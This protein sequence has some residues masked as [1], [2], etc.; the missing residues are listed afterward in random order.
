MA[1]PTPS[2]PKRPR[3][4]LILLIFLLTCAV[5]IYLARYPILQGLGDYLVAED[6]LS[7]CE[8]MFVLSG[9]SLDRGR[10]AARLLLEEQAADTLVCLGGEQSPV[11]AAL[12]IKMTNA[13]L[14]QHTI[15]SEGVD[16]SQVYLL[17]EGS[18]TWEEYQAIKEY[19]KT[20]AL[21]KIMVVSSSFHTRRIQRT[22]RPGMEEL[23]IELVVRGAPAGGFDEENWWKSEAGL[24]FL[25]NEYVK[26]AYYALKY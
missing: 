5:G 14:T 3:R 20:H 7:P 6:P 22:F 12:D 26:L 1:S 2:R 11:L 4:W 19:C 24:I 17:P 16:S 8:T 18:S 21:K 15:L 10:E 13:A 23:G 9:N 25:N